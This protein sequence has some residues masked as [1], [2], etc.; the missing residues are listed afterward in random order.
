MKTTLNLPDDLM[1]TVK[2]RALLE[3]KTLQETIAE[4]LRRGLAE[5]GRPSQS[6]SARVRLPLV[7]CVHEA[8]P[9]YELT[10][11]RSAQVLLDEEAHGSL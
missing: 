7:E 4:L 1:R 11:E 3:N 5:V 8:A 6:V 2:M 9:G 10:P